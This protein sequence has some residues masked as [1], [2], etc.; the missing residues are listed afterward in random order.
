MK[1]GWPKFP[2][3]E[4]PAGDDALL[5][6]GP[7]D[8]FEAA[9]PFNVDSPQVRDVLREARFLSV[10]LVDVTGLTWEEITPHL[11]TVRDIARSKE[12]VPVLIVDLVDYHGLIAE[13]LAY[14]TLPNL[15]AN[16]S[17]DRGLD[18][19]A[20]LARRRQILQEK[21]RP[22]AIINLGTGDEWEAP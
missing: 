17:L 22:A 21:W 11:A 16:C 14:D 19:R 2:G 8:A 15:A 10:M 6:E 3:D 20:Y 1:F 5:P 9:W 13:A 7:A 4:T 12:M 18:W